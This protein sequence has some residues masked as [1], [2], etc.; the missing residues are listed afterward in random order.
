MHKQTQRE[1]SEISWSNKEMHGNGWKRGFSGL[2]T[3]VVVG[4]QE[5]ADKAG[6]SQHDFAFRIDFSLLMACAQY[7]PSPR[8]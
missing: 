7:I 5:L 3:K 2:R 4:I 1:S 8:G 6:F